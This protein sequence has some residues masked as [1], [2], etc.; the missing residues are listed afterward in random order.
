M[1]THAK[2]EKELARTIVMTND[3]CKTYIRL[4]CCLTCNLIVL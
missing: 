4:L 3:T 2:E 1:M